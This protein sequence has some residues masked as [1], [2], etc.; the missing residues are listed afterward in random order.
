M[1]SLTCTARFSYLGHGVRRQ[2]EELAA[3]HWPHVDLALD[4]KDHVGVVPLAPHK[5]DKHIFRGDPP[6]MYPG[7]M[8]QSM[9]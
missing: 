1:E 9:R 4:L 7:H 3:D 8:H 2:C 5:V 6:E